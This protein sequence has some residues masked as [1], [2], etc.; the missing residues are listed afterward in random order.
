MMFMIKYGY[1]G[2]YMADLWG[3]NFDFLFGNFPWY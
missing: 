3:K 1:T 2:L